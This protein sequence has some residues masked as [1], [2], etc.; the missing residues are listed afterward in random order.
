MGTL[1]KMVV[2][3][4]GSF[5]DL[6]AITY[7]TAIS[8]RN[9]ISIL[10]LKSEVQENNCTGNTVS[11]CDKH[12]ER[13]WGDIE[14]TINY[15]QDEEKSDI[16][17]NKQHLLYKT[18]STQGNDMDNRHTSKDLTARNI[19]DKKCSLHYEIEGLHFA[20]LLH[21]LQT[22]KIYRQLVLQNLTYCHA[23]D[24][25]NGTRKK[26]LIQW[27]LKDTL[28]YIID[29]QWCIRMNRCAQERQH[30][31]TSM[32][33]LST[34]GGACSALG[35]YNPRFALRA[36]A[37][38]LEQLEIAMRFGD[39]GIISRCRLYAAISFIQQCKFRVSVVLYN[40]L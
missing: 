34:L 29:D 31:D 23:K 12:C 30:L 3:A 35:D 37:I 39:P 19:L 27:K 9:D 32:S 38:S 21:E 20:V 25:Q 1:V 8:S 11:V 33:W 26:L 13:E 5:W 18:D 36:G 7:N 15:Q 28:P 22:S 14:I 4:G 40:L 10:K 16:S 6:I 2:I 24:L 17:L